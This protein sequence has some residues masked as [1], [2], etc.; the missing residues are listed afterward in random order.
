MKKYYKGLKRTLKE[1]FAQ[2]YGFYDDSYRN[3][4]ALIAEAEKEDEAAP[5]QG[6]EEPTVDTVKEGGDSI[7]SQIDRLFAEYESEAKD[8]QTES[9]CHK[10]F[11][12][13]EESDFTDEPGKMTIDDINVESFTNDIVRLIDNYDSLLEIRDAI[14]QRAVNFLAKSYNK[15]VVSSFTSLL[16]DQ[17]DIEIGKSEE[18]VKD[19]KYQAPPA[20]RSGEGGGV[21]GGPAGGV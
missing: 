15:D 8:V 5:E 4:L 21:G 10:N 7:D 6:P 1:S 12:L 13:F 19:E 14:A 3:L 20:D 18:V 11:N 9:V 16:S 2:K 17:H